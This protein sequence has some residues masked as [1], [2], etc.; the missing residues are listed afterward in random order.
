MPH[1]FFSRGT[2]KTL[3]K[4]VRDWP[5]QLC[6]LYKGIN[7]RTKLQLSGWRTVVVSN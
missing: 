3:T 2:P 6:K 4:P 5:T 1:P 7:L